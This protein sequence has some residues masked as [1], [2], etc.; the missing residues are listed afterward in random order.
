MLPKPRKGPRLGGGHKH[1][2]AIIA[3]L[4][5]ELIIHGRITTTETKAK[6]A[7]PMV[8]R[9]ITYAKKGDLASRRRAL[10]ILRD[11]SVVHKLFAELAP[12]Y[13]KRDGG[14]TRILKLGERS[15][16]GAPMAILELL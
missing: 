1:E 5:K 8:E 14:Y 13:E 10:A 2:K 12:R 15:G 6:A 7:R 3:N 16:D 11:K 4:A 9:L